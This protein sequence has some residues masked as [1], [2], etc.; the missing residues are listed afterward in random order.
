MPR[1]RAQLRAAASRAE[2]HPV[3][4]IRVFGR[5]A[6]RAQ[7]VTLTVSANERGRVPVAILGGPRP[8]RGRAFSGTPSTL[9]TTLCVPAGGFSEARISAPQGTI[10]GDRTVGVRVLDVEVQELERTCVAR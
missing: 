1:A 6:P 5:D 2:A 7:K 10:T 9:S 8:V 3:L 4:V